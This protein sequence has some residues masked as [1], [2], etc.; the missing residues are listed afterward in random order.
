MRFGIDPESRQDRGHGCLHGLVR[1][2][3]Q[4]VVSIEFFNHGQPPRAM[5]ERD[6]VLPEE[7]VGNGLAPSML[8]LITGASFPDPEPSLDDPKIVR[9]RPL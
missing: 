3:E 2:R 9:L 7:L 4:I 8:E 5:G 6:R 1:S